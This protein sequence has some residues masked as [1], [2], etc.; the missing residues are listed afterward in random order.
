VIVTLLLVWLVILIYVST[1]LF[2]GSDG[3]TGSAEGRVDGA[4]NG[5]GAASSEW[6]SAP[7]QKQLDKGEMED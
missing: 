3:M 4:G 1:F 5:A 6:S 7:L 2:Q